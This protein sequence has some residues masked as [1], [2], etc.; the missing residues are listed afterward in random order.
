MVFTPRCKLLAV[1]LNTVRVRAAGN[2]QPKKEIGR[3]PASDFV[4]IPVSG[5]SFLTSPARF[6]DIDL[7]L[8][9]M[10]EPCDNGHGV[11]LFLEGLPL[12][13]KKGGNYV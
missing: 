3:F 4:K 9:T 2:P 12:I 5:G 8:E 1:L 13:N 10:S 6:A 11:L 7:G